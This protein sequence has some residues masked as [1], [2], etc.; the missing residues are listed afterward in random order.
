MMLHELID[1]QEGAEMKITG[2]SSRV[3]RLYLNMMSAINGLPAVYLCASNEHPLR[4]SISSP[5]KPNFHIGAIL[6][7]PFPSYTSPVFGNIDH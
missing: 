2:K 5:L 4:I 6:L 3:F 7:R 1:C